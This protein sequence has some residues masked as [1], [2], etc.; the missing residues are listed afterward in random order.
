MYNKRQIDA[1]SLNIL[2]DKIDIALHNLDYKLNNRDTFLYNQIF[3]ILNIKNDQEEAKKLLNHNKNI[4]SNLG[5]SY[6]K[7]NEHN[8]NNIMSINYISWAKEN[9]TL[10]KET[11]YLDPRFW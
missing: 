11:Y 9:E 10:N 4:I 2:H 8:I 1:A 3:A 6:K 7:I 5:Y